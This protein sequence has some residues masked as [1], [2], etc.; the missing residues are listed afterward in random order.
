MIFVVFLLLF[1]NNSVLQLKILKNGVKMSQI[2]VKYINLPKPSF[3]KRF[4]SKQ[5]MVKMSSSRAT[6]PPLV[7][8]RQ[9]FPARPI[10]LQFSTLTF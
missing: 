6:V 1:F 9:H 4:E 10:V 7:S 2:N 3:L 8:L 5:K